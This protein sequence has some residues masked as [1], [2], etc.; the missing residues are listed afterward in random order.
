MAPRVTASVTPIGDRLLSARVFFEGAPPE[1]V[2]RVLE[3]ARSCKVSFCLRRRTP[4]TRSPLG[5]TSTGSEGQ[6]GKVARLVGPYG[7]GTGNREAMGALWVQ[8]GGCGML[9]EALWMQDRDVGCSGGALWVRD[10]GAG[11]SGGCYGCGTG[12]P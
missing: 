4:S 10:G 1:D 3:G 9:E 6:Q 8:H 5:G 2:T 7:C 11:C 12:D